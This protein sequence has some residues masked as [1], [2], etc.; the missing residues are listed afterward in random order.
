MLFVNPHVLHHVGLTDCQDFTGL[1]SILVTCRVCLL[2]QSFI[3]RCLQVDQ[4][5]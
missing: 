4:P 5:C 2:I 1:S 3:E